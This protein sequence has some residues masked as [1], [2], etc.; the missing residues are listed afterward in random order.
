MSTYPTLPIIKI[1]MRDAR[2]VKVCSGGSREFFKRHNL[3][4]NDFLKNGIDSDKLEA[5]G[6]EI[7]INVVKE[8]RNGR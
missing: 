8:A 1:Y 5:T 7:V 6:N 2:H 4:W 3:D